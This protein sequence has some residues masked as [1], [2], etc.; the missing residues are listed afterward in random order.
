MN[1]RIAASGS[2]VT[3][4][5]VFACAQAAAAHDSWLIADQNRINDGEQVWLS[6]V[7]GEIFPLGEKATDPARLDA[8][9]DLYRGDAQPIPGFAVQ[10]KGLSRRGPLGGAGIHVIG[11]ALKPHLIEMD[12]AS[13]E[14]YLRHERAEDAL[15]RF[16][17]ESAGER[18]PASRPAEGGRTA[19]AG[20]TPTL[21]GTT[22]RGPA[23]REIGGDDRE[24]VVE[25]YTKFAKTIIEVAPC[26][27]DDR[28]WTAPLGH[29]LEIIPLDNP[30]QWALGRTVK[31]RVLLDGHPWPDVPVSV[32]YEGGKP[33]E[34][35]TRTKTNGRG[36]AEVKLSR[37]GHGFLKAHFIRPTSGLGRA[38]WESF[39]ASLTFRVIGK[40]DVSGELRSIRGLHGSLTPGGVIG[41]RM[42]QA[43][44]RQLGLR[45]GDAAL[46]VR[47]ACPLRREYASIVDGIQASTGATLGRLAL[48][49]EEANDPERMATVFANTRTGESIRFELHADLSGRLDHCRDDLESEAL[50]LE[51]A[52]LP[53]DVMFSSSHRATGNVGDRVAAQRSAVRDRSN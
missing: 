31:V 2:F 41:Y 10:D 25:S 51:A 52:T 42:G 28:S 4:V 1:R 53:D 3:I 36:E 19:P 14:D 17:A 18:A 34:Y 27:K 20:G 21:P 26:P 38:T 33:H 9:V 7:T 44:L 43:A 35:E 50:A 40:T 22:N 47:H 6:F 32:G 37:A 29:R 30:S 15:R 8:A 48:W 5:A 46:S 23:T 49:I 16:G 39:W 12:R 24:I 13:F 11:C 45:F